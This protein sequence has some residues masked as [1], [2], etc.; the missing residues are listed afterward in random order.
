MVSE[1][2]L[3][4]L[5]ERKSRYIVGTPKCQLKRFDVQ[6]LSGKWSQARE[7][8]D[9]QLVPTE[10]GAETF[11]LCRSLDRVTK[12]CA[13]RERFDGTN[14]TL[15]TT[16]GR[17]LKIRCDVRPEQ[18]QAILLDRLGLELLHRLRPFRGMGQ[19]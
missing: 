11:I 18:A 10:S 7:G 13:I 9:V 17:T 3:K 2:N 8:L 5:Q 12:E 14:V 19:I 6:L 4:W 15:P 16:D 1:A